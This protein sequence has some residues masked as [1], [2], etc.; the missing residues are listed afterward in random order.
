MREARNQRNQL[1]TCSSPTPR[2]ASTVSL[3]RIIPTT[4][5]KVRQIWPQFRSAVCCNARHRSQKSTKR[6]LTAVR[7]S[8]S[9]RS[10]RMHS[11]QRFTTLHRFVLPQSLPHQVYHCPGREKQQEQERLN[12][13]CIMYGRLKGPSASGPHRNSQSAP[14]KS[15]QK[16]VLLWE[17]LSFYWQSAENGRGSR[18]LHFC[19]KKRSTARCSGSAD[20]FLSWQS[21]NLCPRA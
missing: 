1:R 15:L 4:T 11:I 18:L 7:R 13:R 17:I 16:A 8:L 14:M 10:R 21:W 5:N 9:K 2:T 6:T 20:D 19:W 12:S 3:L